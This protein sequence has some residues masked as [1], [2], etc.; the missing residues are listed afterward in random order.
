MNQHFNSLVNHQQKDGPTSTEDLYKDT[1]D[2]MAGGGPRG[3]VPMSV[4]K[5]WTN[6]RRFP[7]DERPQSQRNKSLRHTTRVPREAARRGWR[8]T[9][10]F[11]RERVR[12]GKTEAWRSAARQQLPSAGGT[13]REGLQG[14]SGCWSQVCSLCENLTSCTLNTCAL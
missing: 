10:W 14:A 13:A 7:H 8:H 1:H 6:R 9:V 12:T 5:R 2:R 11:H 4:C 3:T